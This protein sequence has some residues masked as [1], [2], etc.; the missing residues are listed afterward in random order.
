MGKTECFLV[1]KKASLSTLKHLHWRSNQCKRAREK[2]YIDGKG[3]NKLVFFAEDII[4]HV[5]IP[6]AAL[7]NMIVTNTE[8]MCE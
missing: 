5:D 4:I 2:R 6:K 8:Q 7:S 3:R 1:R